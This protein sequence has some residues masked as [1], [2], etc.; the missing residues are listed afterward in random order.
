[1]LNYSGGPRPD[2]RSRRGSGRLQ[3]GLPADLR[4]LTR[5]VQGLV[6]HYF[7]DEH[8]L[9]WTPPKERL[10]EIDARRGGPAMLARLR[11]LDSRPL[12]E[13]RPPERRI[14]GCCRDLTVLLCAMARHG[15]PARARIGLREDVGSSMPASTPITR[16]SSGGTRAQQRWRLVDPELTE[17]PRRAFQDRLRSVRRGPGGRFLRRRP[18]LATLSRRPGGAG[19]A[20]GSTRAH[21]S[22]GA[23][24]SC[25][26]T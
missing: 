8:I 20:S 15:D 6:F 10:P 5:V 1:M 13:P 24:A 21:R 11:M 7:A 2:H 17:R 18:G 9:G 23:W 22:R 3:N 4:A 26:A 12:T 25:E 14:L 16:S 19:T